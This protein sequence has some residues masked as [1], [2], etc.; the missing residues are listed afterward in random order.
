MNNKC[1]VYR[2]ENVLNRSSSS[3][4]VAMSIVQSLYS[5]SDE[6]FVVQVVEVVVVG[7]RQL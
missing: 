1:V 5:V 4:A 7:C 2:R 6:S 3:R